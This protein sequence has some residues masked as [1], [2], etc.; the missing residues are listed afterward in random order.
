MTFARATFRKD[1]VRILRDPV[2]LLFWLGIPLLIGGLMT[3]LSG[4]RDGPKPQAH[5]LVVDLDDSFLSGLLVGALSQE[6][7]GSFV[8]AEAVEE[9]DGRARIAQGDGSALL[10]IPEGFAQALLDDTPTTLEL[11]KNPAQQILPGIVEEGLSIVV[12]GAF[13]VQRL[14][15]DQVR[16]MF[17]AED[18][19]QG[20]SDPL[21][22]EVSV[23]INRIIER[24]QGVLFPPVLEL[25]L[26]PPPQVVAARQAAADSAAAA[27]GRA[28]GVAAE[29]EDGP[30]G[31]GFLFLPALLF[32]SLLFIAQG[33]A[34]DVWVERDGRTLRRVVTSPRRV[35]EFLFGKA[36]AGV[37]VVTV[38][39]GIALAA[40]YAYFRIE[41]RTYP[42]AVA[43]SALSGAMLL[44]LL[45]VIK[46]HAANARVSDV[47]SMAVVFPLMMLGGSFFPFE[48]MPARMAAIGRLT[49]NGWALTRLKE[50]LAGDLEA[51]SLA[52]AAA[53]LFGGTALL[54][55]WA[56]RRLGGR[57]AR[58]G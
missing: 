57:F 11:V 25:E 24:L 30:G 5:V 33:I 48:A 51:G 7:A 13:Y 46:L 16:P 34:S 47:L 42:V 52:V 9:E 43:W 2:A 21:V 38:I 37:L 8:R 20:P 23:R 17:D 10:V 29:E 28:G 35:E 36:L 40:G 18:L 53:A 19:T 41:W 39:A 50:I 55:F 54:F 14:A 15:G 45:T 3:L 32:M 1:V 58:G 44:Q 6:A 22:S 49:P 31:I 4:G 56:A 27:Q 12:D 26:G